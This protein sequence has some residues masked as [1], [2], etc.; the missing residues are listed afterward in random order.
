MAALKEARRV[1]ADLD[2]RTIAA[3]C[4]AGRRLKGGAMSSRSAHHDMAGA[5]F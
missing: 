4:H 5:I 1:V 3:R 2:G